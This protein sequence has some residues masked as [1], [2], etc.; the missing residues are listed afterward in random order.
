MRLL[1]QRVS[2]ASVTVV[3]ERISSI[4][5]G[6]LIFVGIGHEDTQKEA[7][8]LARKAAGLRIFEDADGNTN[9]SLA[10]VEGAALVVSQFTLYADTRK[11][12]RP[13][14]IYA[15]LPEQAE[16]LVLYFAE[17]LTLQ[18]VPVE[19]GRFGAEMDVALVNDG[20]FTLW[21]ERDPA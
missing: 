1:I 18:N 5:K 10:D 7:D 3:G 17:Q 19:Q 20:P 6:V 12:R 4:G 15:A 16:S 21:L 8:W 14:F 11:G 13:S 2:E 9:L